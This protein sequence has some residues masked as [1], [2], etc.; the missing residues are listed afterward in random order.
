VDSYQT[1]QVAFSSTHNASAIYQAQFNEAGTSSE[2]RPIIL[3]IKYAPESGPLPLQA[4]N[5]IRGLFTVQEGEE[6]VTRFL[7]LA[8][9]LNLRPAATFDDGMGKLEFVLVSCKGAQHCDFSAAKVPE[10][11]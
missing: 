6:G 8:L 5:N 1:L 9:G 7:N 11:Q 4:N 3:V 10:Q 2:G